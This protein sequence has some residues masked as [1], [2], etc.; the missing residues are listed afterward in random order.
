M[1]LKCYANVKVIL[2]EKSGDFF[3]KQS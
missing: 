3:P 2:T 1:L